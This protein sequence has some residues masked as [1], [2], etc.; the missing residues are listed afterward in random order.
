MD[1]TGSGSYLGNFVTIENI[2]CHL[3][4]DTLV[5]IKLYKILNFSDVSLNLDISVRIRIRS[6]LYFRMK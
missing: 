1:T 6:G 2:F 5:I 3:D 4:T